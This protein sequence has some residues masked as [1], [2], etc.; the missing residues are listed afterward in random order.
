M[1]IGVRMYD[2]QYKTSSIVQQWLVPT[3]DIFVLNILKEGQYY[4]ITQS[5][6]TCSNEI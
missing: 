5:D 3:M 6:D 4:N 1:I 2:G